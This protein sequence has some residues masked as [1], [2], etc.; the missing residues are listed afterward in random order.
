MQSPSLIWARAATL[1]PLIRLL[2][3][4]TSLAMAS[5]LLYK[6]LKLMLAGVMMHTDNDALD[7]ESLELCWGELQL[8]IDQ[9]NS[10]QADS[11]AARQADRQTKIHKQTVE[12][13]DRRRDTQNQSASYTTTEAT[14]SLSAYPLALSAGR[15]ASL[16]SPY[17]SPFHLLLT[18]F[19]TLSL[20]LSQWAVRTGALAAAFSPW[21]L[22]KRQAELTLETVP[23]AEASFEEKFPWVVTCDEA[24]ALVLTELHRSVRKPLCTLHC[25]C[26]L[27]Y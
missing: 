18:L 27:A 5:P 2:R 20:T 9:I 4:D 22:S 26:H 8:N 25:T 3:A 14:A 17:L 11:Q 21:L 6:L 13:L 24:G 15:R 7:H 19:L 10:S 12:H 23:Q 16:F 1:R